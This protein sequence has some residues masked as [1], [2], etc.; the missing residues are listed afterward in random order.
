MD[1]N[2]SGEEA[3]HLRRFASRRW[4]YVSTLCDAAQ[5]ECPSF[6]AGSVL[7]WSIEDPGWAAGSEEEKLAVFRR[8]R[9]RRRVEIMASGAELGWVS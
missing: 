3:K 7:H 1:I 6:E 4:D 8:V 9:D 5:R 2:I